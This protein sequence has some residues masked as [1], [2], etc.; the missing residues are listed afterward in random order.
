[1][2]CRK[3]GYECQQGII[4]THEYGNFDFMDMLDMRPASI[5]WIPENQKDNFVRKIKKTF[6]ASEGIGF[7]CENCDVLYAEF[8][9]D[10]Y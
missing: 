8:T 4:E 7:Y 3:C 6:E 2:I 1:M 10:D 5:R 9:H